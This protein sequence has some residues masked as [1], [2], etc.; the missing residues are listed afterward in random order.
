MYDVLTISVLMWN[1][2]VVWLLIVFS[3][4]HSHDVLYIQ[5]K[6]VLRTDESEILYVCTYGVHMY[7]CMY[8]LTTISLPLFDA[9]QSSFNPSSDNLEVVTIWHLRREVP[10][11][12]SFAECNF[13]HTY[14]LHDFILR[15]LDVVLLAQIFFPNRIL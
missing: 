2:F 11:P 1:W 4:V 13:W 5:R 7:V 9:E 12:E 6:C 3:H 10:R 8:V 14:S 15:Y